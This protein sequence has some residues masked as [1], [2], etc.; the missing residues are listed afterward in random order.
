[1]WQNFPLVL[2]ETKFMNKKY[3]IVEFS[4]ALNENCFA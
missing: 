1:M 3:S 2:F 4:L